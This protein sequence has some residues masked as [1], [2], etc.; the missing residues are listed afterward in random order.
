MTNAT[1]SNAGTTVL[2]T[3]LSG[4]GKS[5]LAEHTFREVTAMAK[6]SIILDGDMLRT[7]LNSDLGFDQESRQENVRR[8]GEI[9]KL[10]NREGYIVLVP[11]IAPYAEDRM[12]MRDKHQFD[13]LTFAEVHVS[14]S[15]AVCE[16]RDIKGL[17]AQ[18]RAGK[19]RDFTGVSA[20]YE[21]PSQ[22]DA[23]VSGASPSQLAESVAT[24]VRLAANTL[25][26]TD[27]DTNA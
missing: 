21:V 3:G 14:T 23:R 7:G 8:V 15:L 25:T 9:A 11:I 1:A 27:V 16:C 10:F 12:A 24:I 22:P 20:P 4:A 5:T 6:R 13:G 17:Y 19:V 26:A 18:A 2:L